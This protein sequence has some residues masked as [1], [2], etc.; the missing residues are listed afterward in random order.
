MD[1]EPGGRRELRRQLEENPEWESDLLALYGFDVW[2]AIDGRVP[3]RRAVMLITR[4][5]HEPKSIWRA[6]ALGGPE[7]YSEYVGWEKLNYILADLV[8]GVNTLT[9]VTVGANSGQPP[10][11]D[12][13]PR[14]GVK[15]VEK[16][17][18]LDEF[19]GN[20]LNL[21]GPGI[22]S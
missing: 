6:K 3:V 15:G 20:L 18:S 12:P 16:K 5:E 19:G 8:D 7:L 11:F 4:L 2:D 22:S 17:Q 13:Y 1:F 14:P 10:E 9:A 21:F